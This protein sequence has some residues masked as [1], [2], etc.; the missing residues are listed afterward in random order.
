MGRGVRTG[1]YAFLLL[2]VAHRATR[3]HRWRVDALLRTERSS[4][5]DGGRCQGPDPES[6]RP[7]TGGCNANN[8]LRGAARL[9][10]RPPV[11][12]SGKLLVLPVAHHG[13]TF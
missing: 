11:E 3:V 5:H 6:G 4:P 12:W 8:R 10:D 1:E 13:I 7:P 9:H 2:G